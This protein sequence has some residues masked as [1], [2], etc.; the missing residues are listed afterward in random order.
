[1]EFFILNPA[2]TFIVLVLLGFAGYMLT[3]LIE[4]ITINKAL[5]FKQQQMRV[6]SVV[7]GIRARVT[8]LS[9]ATVVPVAMVIA[10]VVIG[11]NPTITESNDIISISS[12]SD[13]FD[14]Y[15]D[16][17]EKINANNSNKWFQRGEMELDFVITP[18]ASMDGT[19]GTDG[20]SGSDGV[21]GA[22]GSDDYSET[23]NQVVGVDEMDNVLTDGKYI[24]TMYQNRILITLAGVMVGDEFDASLLENY[25]TFEYSNVTCSEDQFYPQGMY[26]D[27]DY[28]VVI[29]NQYNYSCEKYPEGEEPI[30]G[31][32]DIYYEDYYYWGHQSSSIQVKVYDKSNDFELE[33]EYTMDGYFTGTRKIGNSLYIVTNDYI[34]FHDEEINIDEYLPTYDVNGVTVTSEYENIIYVEG[35]SPNSFTTFYGIDLD[36]KEV[37]MEVILG[38][39]GYNLYVSNENM[40]LVGTTYYFWPTIDLVVDT[41]VTTEEVYENKTAILKVSIGNSE[42]EYE[43]IGIVSGYTLNQFSMD[44]YEGNLR[45]TTT[46]G[47]W[48]DSINNRLY[49]L[50]ENL[51]VVSMLE[52]L[53]K[54][55]EQIK[56]T[57][58]VGDYAYLVTFETTDPFYVIDV[59]DPSN[60]TVEGE[61]LIEGYSAYLQPLGDNYIL[62]IGYGD[63]DGGTNGL[64]I[65]IFDVSDKNNPVLLGEE[66]IF[67]YSEFGWGYSSAT[68][69][70]KDLLVSV[71]KGIIALPFSTNSY[72]KNEEDSYTYSYNSG[73]LVYNF[74]FTDGLDYSGYVQHEENSVEDIYVYKSKFIS[75]YFYTVSNKYIKVSTLSDVENILY[76]VNLEE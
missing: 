14:I 43:T 6:S 55:G 11:A 36:T 64:K 76:S 54:P 27:D 17:N 50:D 57:R 62:G 75:E 26:I 72:V 59:S 56:S 29:G 63:N 15:M 66:A 10:F 19:N 71:D 67:D 1:M 47:W 51:K 2:I 42:V 35:T 23:N 9:I 45:I 31:D 48:G 18:E 16:F 38:D 41:A 52:N 33:D 24:Y 53:G 44:E 65:A 61:L 32:I 70:H 30:R 5:N 22:I 34:P 49:I 21:E 73:I 74:D 58:F 13:V 3:K 7:K 60:P 40:Y 28:L 69:N 68:Y 20:T 4:E 25:L 37:D 8:G 12:S 46:E 39:S